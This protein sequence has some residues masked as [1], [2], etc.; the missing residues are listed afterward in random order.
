MGRLIGKYAHNVPA[1]SI[2]SAVEAH[3]YQLI[4]NG[5]LSSNERSTG[6]N[7]SGRFS[8]VGLRQVCL[9]F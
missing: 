8:C 9:T 2:D 5:Y 7:R 6:L 4:V 1:V 3:C